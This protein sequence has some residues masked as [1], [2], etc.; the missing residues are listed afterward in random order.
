MRVLGQE[1]KGL[2]RQTGDTMTQLDD[3]TWE[4]RVRYVCPYLLV[5]TLAPKRNISVHPD[6]NVLKCN[7]CSVQ[8]LK[9]GDF[10]ELTVSYR[11]FFDSDP[12]TGDN[13]TEE[14]VSNTSDAPI[15]THPKFVDEIGGTAASPLNGAVFDDDG[16]F[17]GFAADSEFAGV[18]S[19]LVPSTVYRKTTPTASRPSSVADVGVIGSA[20][21]GGGDKNWLFISRT[22][23]RDGAVYE[24]SEEYMLSGPGGWNN[25]IYTS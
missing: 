10:A 14:I 1:I 15:E 22:W 5:V 8:R 12:G 19:Y 13:S 17:L 11:G 24:V 6:F 7:G 21:I 18:D 4:A 25:T 23:R 16:K 20:P 2:V 3:G 9:P